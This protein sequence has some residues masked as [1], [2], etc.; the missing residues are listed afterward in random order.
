MGS[1]EIDE[2]WQQ[3]QEWLD[4]Y[5]DPGYQLL[6]DEEIISEV[7]TTNTDVEE[8]ISDPRPCVS[9]AQECEAL[10]T[11]LEWLE[12]QGDTQIEHLL[13]VK[14]WRNSAA[15]KRVQTSKQASILSFMKDH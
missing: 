1:S 2:N 13:L 10:E 9:P 11:V 7:L 12:F 3:P 5:D 4:E 15:E 14:K 8:D 6:G